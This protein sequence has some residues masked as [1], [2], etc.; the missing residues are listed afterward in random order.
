MFVLNS[1]SQKEYVIHQQ[2][3]PHL[4]LNPDGNMAYIQLQKL[5]I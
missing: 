2:I 4:S 1:K 3:L 5:V